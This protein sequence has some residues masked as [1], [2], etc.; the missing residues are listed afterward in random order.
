MNRVILTALVTLAA[1]SF[2]R[3]ARADEHHPSGQEALRTTCLD[4]LN[5]G[6][7]FFN[8]NVPY[9]NGFLDLG[10]LPDQTQGATSSP[11][12]DFTWISF[13]PG[14]YWSLTVGPSYGG[15]DINWFSDA[16]NAW[17][18]NHS[19]YEYAVYV[20]QD[21]STQNYQF[22]SYNQMFGDYVPS[23]KTCN[24]DGSGFAS[25]GSPGVSG[26]DITPNIGIVFAV[27]TWQHNDPAIGHTG[28]YCSVP[29]T[30]PPEPAL[31]CWW[32]TRFQIQRQ[33]PITNQP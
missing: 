33:T 10:V 4:A 7:I 5:N 25:T 11:C 26:S 24:H 16:Q 9:G 14:T 3:S 2:V 32:G 18:C 12:D 6:Y 23:S 21:T 29:D 27:R 20:S 22:S 13:D 28:A 31:S 19:D 1:L 8:A 15:P 17:D 30:S